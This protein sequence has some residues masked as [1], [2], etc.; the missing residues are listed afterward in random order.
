MG[1]SQARIFW[2]LRLPMLTAPILTA[3]AIGLAVSVG[4][5][6][7]SLLIGGGRVETLTT[8][9]VALSS[10]GNRRLIG[11][12][13]LLQLAI[14]TLAFGAALAIPG[15]IWRNRHAMRGIA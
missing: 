11:A 14:P 6:L 4:Q 3:A 1:A 10:G 7:P 13:T 12:Y 9:A 5:Y 2:R 15:L 8:E